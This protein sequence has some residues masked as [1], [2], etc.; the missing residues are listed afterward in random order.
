MKFSVD[1]SS[2]E[3][4]EQIHSLSEQ[5]LEELRTAYN[6]LKFKA[7]S[8]ADLT[9]EEQRTIIRWMRADRETKF[10]LNKKP[11]KKVKPPKE[12]KP[13]KEKKKKKLTK[14]E[15]NVLLLKELQGEELTPEE[16]E[17]RDKY[18]ETVT[19]RGV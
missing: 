18:L 13:P 8:G 19:V 15:F 10:I 2:I 16:I 12:P 6:S 3:E 4:K 14:K 7:E 1:L 17:A 9:L 11:E 5:E